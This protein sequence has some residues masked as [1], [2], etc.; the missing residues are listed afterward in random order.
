VDHWQR[1]KR[2]Q[3]ESAELDERERSWMMKEGLVNYV[4]H[5][6]YLC[7]SPNE[8]EREREK[9]ETLLEKGEREVERERD[10]QAERERERETVCIG[11][12]R[13]FVCPQ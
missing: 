8:R 10:R 13:K 4:D 12:L 6:Y 5:C 2:E 11:H 1:K 3:R 7:L 9:L